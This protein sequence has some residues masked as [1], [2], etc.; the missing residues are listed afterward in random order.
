MQ[1]FN[2]YHLYYFH[3]F[4]KQYQKIKTKGHKYTKVSQRIST[5]KCIKQYVDASI[6]YLRHLLLLLFI[7]ETTSKGNVINT[8]K[9]K[10]ETLLDKRDKVQ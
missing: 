5:I 7:Q 8:Q 4:R 1:L 10:E 6:I 9:R 3:L 2:S